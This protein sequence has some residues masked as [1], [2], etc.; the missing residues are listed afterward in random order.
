MAR[1]YKKNPVN[2]YAP[3][4]GRIGKR[5]ANHRVRRCKG[6]LPSGKAYRNLYETW[7]I[8]DVVDRTTLN[9]YLDRWGR[10]IDRCENSCRNWKNPYGGTIHSAINKW[11]KDYLRK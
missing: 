8:H 7:D 4:R 1:S 9:E 11:K 3:V 2:K 6:D 5:F 10:W